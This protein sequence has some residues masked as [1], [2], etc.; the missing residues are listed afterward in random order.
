MSYVDESSASIDYVIPQA[1]LVAAAQAVLG[2]AHPFIADLVAL[3]MSFDWNGDIDQ[4]DGD[5]KNYAVTFNYGPP[6]EDS[7]DLGTESWTLSGKTFSF[8]T[9]KTEWASGS[10]PMDEA[11][12]DPIRKSIIIP[13]VDYQVKFTKVAALPQANLISY[14]GKVNSGAWLGWPDETAMFL[15]ANTEKKVTSDGVEF[16]IGYK[17]T[18]NCATMGGGAGAAM[19]WNKEYRPSTG[20]PAEIDPKPYTATSFAGIFT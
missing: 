4:S 6:T 17:F 15:G 2:T 18:I 9:K 16:N 14:I 12:G 8:D 3:N 20:L 5:W 7:E 11:E 13:M 19:T 1:D 10:V